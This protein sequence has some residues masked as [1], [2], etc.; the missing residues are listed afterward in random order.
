MKPHIGARAAVALTSAAVLPLTVFATPAHAAEPGDVTVA[1]G[2][3]RCN[4]ISGSPLCISVNGALNSTATVM[5]SYQKNSGPDRSISLYLSA[6]GTAKELVYQ[7]SITVPG[8]RYGSR[9]K[10]ISYNSC[11]VGH[12]RIGN[13]QWTTGELL[14]R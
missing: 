7:G 10:Y 8:T 2:W 11:W 9:A 13:T 5:T 1:A 4:D 6:C 3:A 14:T 12:M